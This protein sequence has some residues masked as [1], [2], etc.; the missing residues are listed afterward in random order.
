MKTRLFIGLSLVLNVSLAAAIFLSLKSPSV[1]APAPATATSVADTIQPAPGP[2]EGS[3]PPGLPFH[4]RQIAA[5]DL[6]IYRDHLRAIGCPEP[7]VR[8]IIRAVINERFGARRRNLL[9]PLEDR[10]WDMVRREALVRRQAV[11]QSEWGRALTALAAQR[12]RL[13]VE[14][15]GRDGLAAE[16]EQ[17]TRRAAL[18]LQYSWLSPEKRDRLIELEEKYQ[19]HLVE[20]AATLGLQSNGLLTTGDGD[21]LQE[22]QKEFDESEKQLL[23]PEELAELQLRKSDA[24][25]WAGGLPG[26]NPSEDEW[27]A[28]TQLRSELDEGQS[29]PGSPELTEEERAARQS[30]LQTK[31]DQALKETLG[32]DRFAQYELANNGEF[33]G[34]RNVTRRYGLPDDVAMAA[35]DIQ[36]TALA[37]ARQA[38]DDPNLSPAARLT[39]LTAIQQETERTLS[40]TLGAR[41]FSTYKEYSGDWLKDLAPTE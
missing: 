36:Q 18:E 11:P 20:W 13:I 34:V 3:P 25:D 15:L 31:F 40:G 2:P 4:W 6:K 26:F 24:A 1:T 23:T 30:E 10:Y 39:T 12:Q 32:P 35:Y 8:E 28:M 17:Q 38:G 37:N 9:A 21:R 29:Q 27:R 41:V 16:A 22:W 7:T 19:Q 33:Q 14:V 5:E